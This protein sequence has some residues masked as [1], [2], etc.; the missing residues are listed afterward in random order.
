MDESPCQSYSQVRI[1]RVLISP[2]VKKLAGIQ[3]IFSYVSFEK[4]SLRKGESQLFILEYLFNFRFIDLFSQFNE[5]QKLD[6]PNLQVLN[7]L[8]ANF[9]V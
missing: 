7:L 4:E 6:E 9:L 1:V 3:I 8:Q 5:I 2:L